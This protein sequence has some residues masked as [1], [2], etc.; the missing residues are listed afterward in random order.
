MQSEGR[1]IVEAMNALGYDAMAVGSPDLRNG[2]DV[3]LQ[4]AQEAHFA[5]LSCNILSLESKD[6][7]FP[8]HTIIERDGVRYG[9]LGVSDPEATPG[10]GDV[11]QVLNPVESVRKYLP[12]VSAQSD[13]VILLSHLGLEEDKALAQAV[14]GIDVIV[15]G[16]SRNWLREPEIVGQ[17]IIV[18]AGYDG[19]GL[20]R[21]DVSFDAQ[22]RA[23]DPQVEIIILG[24]DIADDPELSALV[25]SYEEHLPQPT[26]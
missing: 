19:E 24:P 11:A 12:E 20:G 6:L 26:P 5:I 21:L 4:R 23:R 17:T 18:Q 16:R 13:V 25:A 14:P 3:L 15:G 8:P 1:I 7:L 2:L 9:I 22:G 10:L